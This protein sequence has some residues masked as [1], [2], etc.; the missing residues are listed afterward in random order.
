M[1]VWRNLSTF[2]GLEFSGWL[3][4]IALRLII[5]FSR[6]KQPESLTHDDKIPTPV[7]DVWELL[8]EQVA[9]LRPCVDKLP[10]NRRSIVQARLEGFDFAEISRR[11]SV[12]KN[13]AM[14]RFHRAKD[15][16]RQCLEQRAP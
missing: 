9:R 5:D 10:D 4:T 1:R 7:D 15:D 11:F 16:L 13:T 6:K 2:D 12:D 14:T 3:H 8:A